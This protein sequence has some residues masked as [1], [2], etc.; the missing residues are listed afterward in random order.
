STLYGG[1]QAKVFLEQV[2][3]GVPLLKEKATHIT[4]LRD[5]ERAI[6]NSI[7]EFGE[8]RDDASPTLR[9]LRSQIHLYEGKIRERLGNIIRRR[10]KMLSDSIV[11]IR[12]DRYV[13]P[14]KHEYSSAIGGIV[15]DQ[16]ASGQTLFMETNAVVEANNELQQVIVKE[17]H[18]IQQIL[19]RLTMKIAESRYDIEQNLD[20][21]ADIDL[22]CAKAKL[23]RA[24]DAAKPT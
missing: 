10:S 1:R 20:V 19:Q 2:E 5:T 15:H 23:A 8:M 4:S 13:L 16:S 12:N 21:L 11:T 18:E 22:I 14:V 9:Q 7:D 3:A 6:K 17:K 24:M